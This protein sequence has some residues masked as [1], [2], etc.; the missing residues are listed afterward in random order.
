MA[1]LGSISSMRAFCAVRI[2]VSA[3][4]SAVGSMQTVVSARKKIP[5]LKTIM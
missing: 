4:S 5:F 3:S 2:A 1:T